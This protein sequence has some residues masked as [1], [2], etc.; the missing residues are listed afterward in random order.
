MAITIDEIRKIATNTKT[1]EAKK[2]IDSIVERDGDYIGEILEGIFCRLSK[3]NSH[4]LI[5]NLKKRGLPKI[6]A[7]KRSKASLMFDSN[8]SDLIE[9]FKRNK[10]RVGL[11]EKKILEFFLEELSKF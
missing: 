7:S 11:R 5:E 9:S 10:V 3:R 4:N 6:S 1:V 8:Y 2:I